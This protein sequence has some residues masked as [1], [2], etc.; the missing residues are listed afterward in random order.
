MKVLS[1]YCSRNAA[2]VVSNH[3]IA[4]NCVWLK[5]YMLESSGIHLTR[6]S[7]KPLF[8]DHKVLTLPCVNILQL[9]TYAH[10]RI[11]HFEH[12]LNWHNYNTRHNNII[13]NSIHKPSAF[14]ISPFYMG[15]TLYNRPHSTYKSLHRKLFK[16]KVNKYSVLRPFIWLWNP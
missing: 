13:S 14:E 11:Y 12:F 5:I 6:A 9:L 15:L 1:T 16:V 8:V 2:V 10:S 3:L 4:I 7:C